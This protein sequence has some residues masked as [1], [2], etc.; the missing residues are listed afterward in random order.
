MT[1]KLRLDHADNDGD[2]DLFLSAAAGPSYLFFNETEPG[3]DSPFL[4]RRDNRGIDVNADGEAVA[5]GDYD[6]DGDLDLLV[7][8]GHGENQLWQSHL[9]DA[10][11]HNYLVVRALRCLPHGRHRDDI[12]AAV[13]LFDEEGVTPWSPLQ[14]VNGGRGHGS[15][16]PAF[17]HFGLPR[18]PD[19]TYMVEVRFLGD[20][21]EAV[22]VR[23][24]V[25]PGDLPGAYQIL[26]VKSCDGASDPDDDSDDDSS[27]DNSSE[28]MT[29]AAMTT[30]AMTTAAMTT[31]AMTTA[32]M[33]TAAMTTA[34]M[35]T[36]VMTTAKTSKGKKGKKSD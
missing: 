7:N 3:W 27:D 25:V 16:D 17:V 29:T 30:A 13:R 15:Q 36:A 12:G 8:V 22:V 6:R 18:G 34:V 11:P 9:N 32:A 21:D 33:T 14:E 10:G 24:T 2:L 5:F 23:R 4:F 26:E 28:Q 20:G 19:A 35:T 1:G 31:A